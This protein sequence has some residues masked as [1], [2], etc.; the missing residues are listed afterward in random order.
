MAA[1][2]APDAAF[3]AFLDRLMGAESNGRD[4]AA[5]PRSTA[6]GAFQFI[7]STF[8]EVMRRHFPADVANL[9]EQEVLALRT[10]RGFARRAAAAF[11]KDNLDYLIDRGLS[12]TFGDLRLAF[13]LGPSAAARVL[14]A[15]PTKP[16]SQIL[17]NSVI[18]A[19]PFMRGM[20]VRDLVARATRD[21]GGKPPTQVAQ[22]APA[23]APQPASAVDTEPV[24]SAQPEEAARVAEAEPAPQA[25][26]EEAARVAEAEPAPQ[27]QPE[28]P[29][30]VAEAEPAPQAQPEQPARVAD[31]GP[32]K[33]QRTAA[34]RRPAPGVDV[35]NVTCN[36]RLASC[37][38]WID[39]QVNKLLRTKVA[40]DDTR[41]GA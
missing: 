28:Q 39:Q 26:P 33:T 31:A 6:L 19:N 9:R 12:P 27:A 8:L 16:V 36:S 32:R 41:G 21:I 17:G 34:A 3:E 15:Q 30:R 29:A 14:E 35:I 7:R 13:L 40:S 25:Q 2:D 24:P 1:E 20:T 38:R 22:A 23:D 11:S 10:D 18:A 4:T 5:N 37:Q